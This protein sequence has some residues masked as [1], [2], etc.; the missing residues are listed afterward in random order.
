MASWI[1]SLLVIW[2]LGY[3][4][5]ALFPQPSLQESLQ[6]ARKW[7]WSPEGLEA[8]AAIAR[9]HEAKKA[10]RLADPRP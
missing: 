1:I 4:I 9:W 8:Q 10:S 3:V 2:A 7:W 6:E 5:D